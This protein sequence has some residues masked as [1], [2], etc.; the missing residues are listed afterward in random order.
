MSALIMGAS[1]L[2]APSASAA[3]GDT[4]AWIRLWDTQIDINATAAFKAYG[5]ELTVCDNLADGYG[6]WA[7]LYKNVYNGHGTFIK[8]TSAGGR[9][10]CRTNTEN[11]KEGTVVWIK[12]CIR[13]DGANLR[14]KWSDYGHA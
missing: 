12:L 7:G 6:A 10:N 11:V 8:S 14:C 9:G 3:D 2:T 1:L 5:D 4:S 13:K